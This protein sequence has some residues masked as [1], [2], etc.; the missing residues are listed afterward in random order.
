MLD[1]CWTSVQQSGLAQKD[2]EL[3][4]GLEEAKRG[5]CGDGIPCCLRVLAFGPTEQSDGC[6]GVFGP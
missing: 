1:V 4:E 5:Y 6:V 3:D 2:A